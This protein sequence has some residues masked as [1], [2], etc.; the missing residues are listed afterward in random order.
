MM[1]DYIVEQRWTIGNTVKISH[2]RVKAESLRDA[3]D[4]VENRLLETHPMAT[5]RTVAALEVYSGD[6]R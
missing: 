2:E 6:W 3:I 1:T 4:T 5:V